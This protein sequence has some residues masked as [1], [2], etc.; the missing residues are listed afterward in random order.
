[1]DKLHAIT[2]SRP[3]E[4]YV[5][6]ED[7]DGRT[8]YAK[9]NEIIIESENDSYRMSRLGSFS[10]DAGD[11][12][13]KC[14]NQKFTTYDR[15]NDSWKKGNCATERRG[16]WWHQSCGD[17]NLFGLYVRG[18]VSGMKWNGV[19]WDSYRNDYSNKIIQMMVRPI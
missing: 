5:H 1:M 7:F 9:Y 10:G 3:Q 12:M 13:H 14:R 18:T 6:L 19:T 8:R 17:S 15:D 2:K 11:S 4:L 16:P